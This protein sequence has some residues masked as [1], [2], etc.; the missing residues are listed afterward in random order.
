MTRYTRANLF[1]SLHGGPKE[2]SLFWAS[3]KTIVGRPLMKWS[4]VKVVRNTLLALS[5]GVL[6]PSIASACSMTPGDITKGD[7][8]SGGVWLFIPDAPE[9]L[10]N[11]ATLLGSISFGNDSLDI[12]KDG[13]GHFALAW[14]DRDG[15][16]SS[17]SMGSVTTASDPVTPTTPTPEPSSLALLGLG[18]MALGLAFAGRR[19]RPTTVG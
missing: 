5:V 3:K 13:D 16:D 19:F 17:A 18:T 14:D 9:S 2:N 15:D 11:S 8:T 1:G 4:L 12:F 7:G 6:L 10:M